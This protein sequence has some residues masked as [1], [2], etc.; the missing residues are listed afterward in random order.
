MPT[1]LGAGFDALAGDAAEDAA[2]AEVAA[3]PARVVRLVGVELVGPAAR[4]AWPRTLD[5][6]HR[7]R[8]VLEDGAVVDVGGGEVDGQRDAVAVDQEVALRAR[9]APVGRVRAG[10]FAPLFDGMLALSRLA[11]LQSI[12]SAP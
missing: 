6:R 1:E 9:L 5:R 3:T 10:I 2:S 11:R 8:Y 7:L 4:A 12:R